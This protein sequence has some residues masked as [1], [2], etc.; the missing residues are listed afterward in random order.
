MPAPANDNFADAISTGFALSGGYYRS[1]DLP[2]TSMQDATTEVGEPEPNA[3][4]AGSLSHTVWWTFVVPADAAEG[5]IMNARVD[6]GTGTPT[7]LPAPDVDG[8]DYVALYTGSSL[9]TLVRVTEGSGRPNN[10]GGQLIRFDPSRGTRYYLQIGLAGDVDVDR[11]EAVVWILQQA[12]FP[13][14]EGIAFS[15]G[16]GTHDEP[17][18]T[19]VDDPS[20]PSESGP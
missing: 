14:P 11:A 9:A 8:T 7:G 15:F 4:D 18:W 3:G 5:S 10:P 20:Q 16:T 17:D 19:R 2:A 12:E 1:D 13:E 6:W